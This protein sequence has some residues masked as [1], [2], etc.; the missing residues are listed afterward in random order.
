MVTK[1]TTLTVVVQANVLHVN[2]RLRDLAV[3]GSSLRELAEAV[4]RDQRAN[5]RT[6][7][8]T[9]LR[10]RPRADLPW[11]VSQAHNRTEWALA[12]PD[13]RWTLRVFGDSSLTQL[14]STITLDGVAGDT[15]LHLVH[16]SMVRALVDRIES[17]G[18]AASFVAH[19]S[20][21]QSGARFAGPSAGSRLGH[22]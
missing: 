19:A 3:V 20:V 13:L 7:Q 10:Q 8:V 17:D 15:C 6:N 5:R 2:R 4:E 1:R 9:R 14:Q 18:L 12:E 22:A 11:R 21:A 16:L